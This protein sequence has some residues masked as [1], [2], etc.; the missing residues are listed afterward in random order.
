[1]PHSQQDL[2]KSFQPARCTYNL[3]PDLRDSGSGSL[4][5][6]IG[7]YSDVQLGR[8]ELRLD[9]GCGGRAQFAILPVSGGGGGGSVNKAAILD[10]KYPQTPR[11]VFFPRT[12]SFQGHFITSTSPNQQKIA[13]RTDMLSNRSIGCP[14]ARASVLFSLSFYE[15]ENFSDSLLNHI[16]ESENVRFPYLTAALQHYFGSEV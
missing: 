15:C 10:V 14:C 4:G 13:R 8:G 11:I 12:V 9:N 16:F 3:Q 6:V 2:W 5:V 7:Q 1:M